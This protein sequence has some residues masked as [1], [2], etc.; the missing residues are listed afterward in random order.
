MKKHVL[1]VLMLSLNMYMVRA[2]EDSTIK[3][4]NLGDVKIG[5]NKQYIEKEAGKTVYQISQTLTNTGGTLE[6]VLR[7]LPN[8]RVDQQGNVSIQGKQQVSVWVDGKPMAMAE[9]DMNSFNKSIQASSIDNIEIIT[10]PGAKYD[11]QGT[12]G[13]I[14]IKLKKDKKSGTNGLIQA[15]YGY[16]NRGQANFSFNKKADDWNVSTNYGYQK[17]YYDH[18]YSENR[19][20]TAPDTAYHY[21]M[22]SIGE[23]PSESHNFKFGLDYFFGKCVVNYSF[24]LIKSKNSY[25]TE[26][27]GRWFTTDTLLKLNTSPHDNTFRTNYSNDIGF[28]VML[29]TLGKEFSA[30]ATYSY[31]PSMARATYLSNE[32]NANDLPIPGKTNDSKSTGDTKIQNFIGQLDYVTHADFAQRIEMGVKNEQT[33]NNNSFEL[34]RLQGGEYQ[35]NRTY[36]NTFNYYEN[37]VAGYLNIE[38]KISSS[39]S[40]SIGF[41]AEN[42]NIQSNNPMVSRTYLNV[43]PNLR[44]TKKIS[45]MRSYGLAVTSRINRPSFQQLNNNVFYNDPYSTWQGNP[46]LKP[47]T[48]Y[49][50][51]FNFTD[52][53]NKWMSSLDINGASIKNKI[54]E[55]TILDSVG[56][57]R[58]GYY[59]SSQ[60]YYVS[61][62]LYNK[63]D[64]TKSISLQISNTI[65]YQYYE[66][67]AGFN[68]QSIS[69]Y[70]YGLWGNLSWRTKKAGSFECNGWFESGGVNSQGTGFPSGSLDLGHKINF[71][72]HWSLTTN[73]S[74]VFN[75]M[76]FRWAIQSGVLATNGRWHMLNRNLYITLAYKF[77]GNK[78]NRED[79]GLN[80]RLLGGGR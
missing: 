7:K 38:K 3:S 22:L 53:Q 35:I 29:D 1:F 28:K 66:A 74:N 6:D 30:F 72:K 19:T 15:G 59:N 57:S 32:L 55:G 48:E 64:L 77:G 79:R 10:N 62:A 80:Q 44:Y 11:A 36:S 63:F 71:S 13:I 17:S 73:L 31:V 43:F 16:P 26:T 56:I 33:W 24:N 9:A 39:I 25:I 21:N 20:I 54:T 37:I 18:I 4:K 27:T 60:G 5:G 78:P 49:I 14:H 67:L 68:N 40:S 2:Q 58:S 51:T 12:A 45:D 75:T 61:A 34:S 50:L 42:T 76:N 23:S 8:V 47:S 65:T 52:I 70:N 41:R 46:N 69:G